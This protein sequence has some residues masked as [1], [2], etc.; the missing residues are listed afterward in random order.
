[1][2]DGKYAVSI[3]L[4]IGRFKGILKLITNGT[5]VTGYIETMGKQSPFS[6]GIATGNQ[7][8]FSGDFKTIIGNIKYKITGIVNGDKLEIDAITNNGNFKIDGYRM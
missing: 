7:F 2:I 1:M 3:D 4:P 6:G 5:E 8:S